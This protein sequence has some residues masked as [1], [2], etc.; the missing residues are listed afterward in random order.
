VTLSILPS[1]LSIAITIAWR[2]LLYQ[3][4]SS[5]S[6]YFERNEV[7]PGNVEGIPQIAHF[8]AVPKSR[9]VSMIYRLAERENSAP[10]RLTLPGSAAIEPVGNHSELS[11]LELNR[12][13]GLGYMAGCTK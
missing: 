6:E 8:R 1:G 9:N 7:L 10:Q 5:K 4:S 12:V 13:Y 2:K 11:F 3:R